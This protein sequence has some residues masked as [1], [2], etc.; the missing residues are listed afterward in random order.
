MTKAKS[1]HL[2]RQGLPGGPALTKNLNLAYGRTQPLKNLLEVEENACLPQEIRKD[3]E[4]SM[5]RLWLVDTVSAPRLGLFIVPVQAPS[6]CE[7]AVGSR[8]E[9]PEVTGFSLGPL[10]SLGIALKGPSPRRQPSHFTL[11]MTGARRLPCPARHPL[12]P[13][14][15]LAFGVCYLHSVC[16]NG[17]GLAPPPLSGDTCRVGGGKH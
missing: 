5:N 16:L 10:L 12:R 3:T 15:C 11:L 6:L 13:G 17:E 8:Q 4:F 9:L 7:R 14:Q 2:G 1:R